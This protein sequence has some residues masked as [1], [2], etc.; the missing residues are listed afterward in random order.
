MSRLGELLRPCAPAAGGLMLTGG[1]T[2]SACCRRGGRPLRLV[3]EIDTGVVLSETIGARAMPV[4]TK[5]GSFG[6]RGT[7]T[8]AAAAA[9]HVRIFHA[10]VL[11]CVGDCMHRPIIADHDGRRRGHRSR[12]YRQ[13]ARA[14][15]RPAAVRALVIGDAEAG[16]GGGDCRRPRA[17]A[18][19]RRPGRRESSRRERSTVSISALIP[20]DL[21][22]GQ[23]SAV[24]GD[25]AYRYIERAVALAMAGSVDAICT[26]PLNKEALRAGGHDFPGHTELLAHLTGTPEVSMMLSA[27]GLRVIHCTTH[28]GLI[29]A[30][31]R[32]DPDLVA[33]TI[34]RGHEA[35][36]RAGIAAP[37]I[38]VAASTRTPG[39][40]ACSAA[41]RKNPSRAGRG[42]RARG[43]IDAVG[44]LPA[45]TTFFRAVRGDFDLVVAMYH[46]QGHCPVKVLGLDAGV[47]I[48]IGL[49]VVRTSVDHGTAFDIAGSGTADERSLV[50]ALRQASQLAWSYVGSGFRQGGGGGEGGGGGGGEGGGGGGGT[51]PCWS[52]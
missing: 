6:D 3:E 11:D 1:D 21:P 20:D 22:F 25:A 9:A 50:E 23:L 14:S 13:G 45:D 47:N 48:T 30:I 32:I 15:R 38:A 36:V 17:R 42:A 10:S 35:L 16:E 7:I 29:D 12:D 24:A 28:I 43:R 33:R 2:A 19:R 46:D 41:A 49:P 4:V 37:R 34:S 18:A 40:T 5:A 52:A 31:A 26:A 51:G 27:P 44:P 39:S 8:R